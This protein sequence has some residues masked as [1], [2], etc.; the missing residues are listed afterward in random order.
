MNVYYVRS[1]FLIL[2]KDSAV[3]PINV[4]ITFEDAFCII[5]G[6][7]LISFRYLSIGVSETKDINLS[8]LS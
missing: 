5:S 6:C 4:A 7:F 8:V 2:L 3:T 1:L